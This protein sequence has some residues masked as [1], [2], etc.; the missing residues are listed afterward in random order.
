MAARSNDGLFQDM[1]DETALL[2][3]QLQLED[4]RQLAGNFQHNNHGEESDTEIAFGLAREELERN[5]AVLQDH[6]IAAAVARGVRLEVAIEETRLAARALDVAVHD[7][8]PAH[9]QPGKPSSI[10]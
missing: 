9:P 1:D 10:F 7:A 2:I 4:S 3:L 5:A 6:Q 8:L